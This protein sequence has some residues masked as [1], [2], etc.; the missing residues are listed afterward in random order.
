MVLGIARARAFVCGG[1]GGWEAGG[2]GRGKEVREGGGVW[3]KE[4]VAVV[5][6]W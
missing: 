3:W 5:E 6:P 2:E 1:G 4:R